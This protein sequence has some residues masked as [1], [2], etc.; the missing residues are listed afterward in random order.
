VLGGGSNI[1]FT[2]DFD[3]LVLKNEL[4]GI[5]VVRE[6][7][8]H[9]FVQTAAGENWHG[10][11][12]HCINNHYAGVENLSLIPGC[13]GAAPMQNIGAYGVEIKDVFHSLEAL[14]MEDQIVKTFSLDEC[15]FGYRESIFKNRERGK[16]IIT[17]MTLK[18]NKRPVFQ[19][20]YGAI[21]EE[22]EKMNL[23]RLN[24]GAI[25]RAVINIR[26]T[27]LPNPVQ[28]G[29]AGSFF[30]NPV[31]SRVVFE[32]IKAQHSDVVAY[33]LSESEVKLAAGWLIDRAGWKGK[34]F[35]NYGV[36]HNQALVLVNYGGATGQEIFS[37]SQ[38]IL[39]DVEGKFGVRLV[40]E[41]NLV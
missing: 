20:H 24:I 5:E 40:R 21:E 9:F 4:R 35:G 2:R 14:H 41:V 22:L 26:S 32:N 1:L 27:K 6:D 29:N 31:V 19:T 11:V 12:L 23:D 10:L 25:S 28:M 36:H 39:E 16:W 33:P 3:G 18:L 34:S 15:E 7:D 37:M 17:S 8:N 30:K 38:K 13:A